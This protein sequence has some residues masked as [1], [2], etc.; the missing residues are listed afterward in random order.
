MKAPKYFVDGIQEAFKHNL[1]GFALQLMAESFGD[2]ED[3][4]GNE[5]VVMVAATH[6]GKPVYFIMT[7]T[8]PVAADFDSPESSSNVT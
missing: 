8:R 3:R 5:N 2:D 4:F 1:N 7:K 6:T